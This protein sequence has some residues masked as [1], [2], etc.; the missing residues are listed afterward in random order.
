MLRSDRK[1]LKQV[2]IE[3]GKLSAFS[4]NSAEG[5]SKAECVNKSTA[6]K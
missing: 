2:F 1:S 4:I 5:I 6:P 3:A